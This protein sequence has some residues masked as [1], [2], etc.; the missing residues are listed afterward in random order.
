MRLT[1][2]RCGFAGTKG[3]RA[4]SISMRKA[5]TTE[6]SRTAE[7]PIAPKRHSRLMIRPSRAWRRWN[8]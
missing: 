7:R 3:P 5:S 2:A 1:A 4:N 8:K 6:R